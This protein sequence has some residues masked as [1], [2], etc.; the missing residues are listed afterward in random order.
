MV[1]GG[2]VKGAASDPLPVLPHDLVVGLDEPHG[3]NAPETDDELGAD[4][5]NLLAEILD[6]NVLL[7]GKGI[8]V[9]GRAAF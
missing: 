6:A 7:G 5:P 2:D 3:G 9:L 4:E 8:A 1:D